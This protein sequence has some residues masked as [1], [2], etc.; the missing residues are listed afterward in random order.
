MRIALMFGILL[1]IAGIPTVTGQEKAPAPKVVRA[2]TARQAVS[3][4]FQGG[5]LGDYVRAIS[6]GGT[7][8]NVIMDTEIG[9]IEVP[10]I[11]LKGVSFGNA[12][13]AVAATSEGR[14]RGL[15]V[16][17]LESG[18]EGGQDVIILTSS[19]P[20]QMKRPTAAQEPPRPVPV[21]K[22]AR[23]WSARE[24]EESKQKSLAVALDRV[25]SVIS[26]SVEKP[27]VTFDQSLGLIIVTGSAEHVEIASQLIGEMQPS[28]PVVKSDYGLELQRL[29]EEVDALKA[30][31]A[32]LSQVRVK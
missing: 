29:A 31:V 19:L 5:A 28:R 30:A 14:E 24:W 10:A 6:G 20:T 26:S 4:E 7:A 3:V 17:V 2:G 27:V 21:Q 25:F 12:L 22:I 23:A 32:R 1:A 8:P 16:Q 15:T 13:R 9:A 11:S 18:R